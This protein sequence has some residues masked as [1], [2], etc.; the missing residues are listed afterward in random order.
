M[1]KDFKKPDLNAPRCRENVHNIATKAF[2]KDFVEKY[3]Q[4]KD[5]TIEQVK[6][7]LSTFHG[8]MWNHAVHNRDGVE[9]PEGL[10][11]IFVGTC[12]PAKSYVIDFASSVEYEQKI[13]HRNFESDNY[14]AK[15]FYTNFASKYKFKNREMWWFKGT[16]DFKRAVAKVYPEKW[17]MYVQVENGKSISKYMANLRKTD[18]INKKKE[19]FEIDPT[20]NEF[21]I[22]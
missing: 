1:I 5:L 13:R 4:Y 6:Q 8:K 7:I 20:Y 15:I 12:Q 3:P 18:A 9:L 2:L 16:R 10:G 19:S 14:L 21:D 11:F 22:D 17:K